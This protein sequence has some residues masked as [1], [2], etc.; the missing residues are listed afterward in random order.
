MI[1]AAGDLER[2]LTCC[3]E[4]PTFRLLYTGLTHET[5]GPIDPAA[6]RVW[7][8]SQVSNGDTTLFCCFDGRRLDACMTRHATWTCAGICGRMGASS[9]TT[10]RQ[11]PD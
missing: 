10:C 3:A 2:N 1:A 11:R 7:C 6:L 8:Q 4:A 9:C 5:T